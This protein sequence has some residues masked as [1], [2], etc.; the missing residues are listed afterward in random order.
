MNKVSSTQAPL[1][2]HGH[3]YIRQIL[4]LSMLSGRQVIIKSIRSQHT[5]PGLTPYEINLV[6]LIEKVTNGCQINI[7]KTGT[8][9][10]FKPGIIDSNEGLNVEHN[11]D[12]GRN[13][14][15]YLEVVCILAI[16]GKT[17]L[18][19]TLNGNTDDTIDQSVDSFAR[20][21]TYI[22]E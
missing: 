5:N 18:N 1:E 8:K 15:Y 13:I 19:L 9:L 6:E 2:F 10:V 3:Q 14:T 17:E 22:L 21:F 4:T 16:F 7:N 11:C 20:A 12:L